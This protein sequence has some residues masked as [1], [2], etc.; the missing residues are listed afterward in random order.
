VVGLGEA[1]AKKK[2]TAAACASGKVTRKYSTQRPKG[3]VLSQNPTANFVVDAGTK[4]NLTVSK[5]KKPKKK[6]KHKPRHRPKHG[7][8]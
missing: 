7:H 1:V 2:I 8:Q 6:P 3:K 4:V 5:G